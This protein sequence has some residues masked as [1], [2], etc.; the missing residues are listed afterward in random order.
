MSDERMSD[1]RIEAHNRTIRRHLV[2]A[3]AQQEWAKDL[4]REKLSKNPVMH[5]MQLAERDAKVIACFEKGLSELR[6]AATPTGIDVVDEDPQNK[7]L[8]EKA[9]KAI[10]VFE[11]TIERVKKEGIDG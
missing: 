6:A 5:V 1:P 9:A 4:C 3:H 8:R 10:T 7:D 11:S 2:N